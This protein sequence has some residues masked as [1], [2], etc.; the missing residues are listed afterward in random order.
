MNVLANNTPKKH[1]EKFLTLPGI[2]VNLG[3]EKS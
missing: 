2:G 3:V 1:G